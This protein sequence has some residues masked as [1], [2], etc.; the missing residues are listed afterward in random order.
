[1]AHTGQVQDYCDWC[2][3]KRTDKDR[4]APANELLNQVEAYACWECLSKGR[5]LTPPESLD[6]DP[7][8]WE[9]A[10]L[11]IYDGDRR[12]LDLLR[13]AAGFGDP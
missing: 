4:R 10:V 2:F 6:V 5:I 3:A 13:Q 12:A 11:A 7:D 1:M 8:E 9:A